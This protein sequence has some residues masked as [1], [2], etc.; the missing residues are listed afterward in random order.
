[1]NVAVEQ[2]RLNLNLEVMETAKAY[3]LAVTAA[4]VGLCGLSVLYLRLE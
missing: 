1:M 3:P 4:G 2:G